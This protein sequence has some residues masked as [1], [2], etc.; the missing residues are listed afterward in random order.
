MLKGRN[1]DQTNL[2]NNTL[3]QYLTNN[4][5]VLDNTEELVALGI[6]L[7]ENISNG[8]ITVISISP[9]DH[10]KTT[11]YDIGKTFEELE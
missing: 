7:L 8:K 3:K 9:Y 2:L 1:D 5:R 4:Y 11:K 10:L 6:I